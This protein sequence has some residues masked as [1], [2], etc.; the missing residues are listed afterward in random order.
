MPSFKCCMLRLSALLNVPL[1]GHGPDLLTAK[2]LMLRV[3]EDT[4]EE[5]NELPSVTDG[6]SRLFRGLVS[7][8]KRVI[9]YALPGEWFNDLREELNDESLD[10]MVGTKSVRLRPR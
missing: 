1:F 8:S 2:W 3:T 5:D 10:G 7:W 9:E 6:K 4:R